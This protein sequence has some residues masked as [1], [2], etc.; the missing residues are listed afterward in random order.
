MELLDLDA[1]T[2][3]D[4]TAFA[5]IGVDS[6]ALLEFALRLEDVFDV[7]LPEEEV[8]ELATIGA[9]VDALVAKTSVR[10]AGLQP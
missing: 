1:A 7:E 4:P 9:L 8:V 6:L 3:T 2:M 10:S 5:D